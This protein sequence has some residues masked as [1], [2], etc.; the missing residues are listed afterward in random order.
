MLWVW[1][2]HGQGLLWKKGALCCS[3]KPCPALS[4][5]CP[6]T[7]PAACPGYS[8]CLLNGQPGLVVPADTTTDTTH[9][10]R[11]FLAFLLLQAREY[12]Y[13]RVHGTQHTTPVAIMTS[14]AKG[15]HWR[16][17]Q[18][19]EAA[20]W[21]GRGRTAFRWADGARGKGQAWVRTLEWCRGRAGRGCYQAGLSH[22]LCRTSCLHS[23]GLL[24][25]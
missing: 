17:K 1:P 21:F 18:A 11:L 19:F 2:L 20:G 25:R 14:A 10:K 12:L 7:Q 9:N 8:P 6:H 24:G 22:S 15:N 4:R 13:W 3:C 16:V 5:S 23:S